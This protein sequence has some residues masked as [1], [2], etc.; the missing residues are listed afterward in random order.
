MTSSYQLFGMCRTII[1]PAITIVTTATFNTSTTN[2]TM[3]LHHLCNNHCW[4]QYLVGWDVGSD[5]GVDGT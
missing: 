5:G 1:T 3:V 4:L 2:N